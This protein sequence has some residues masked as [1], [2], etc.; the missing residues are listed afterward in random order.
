MRPSSSVLCLVAA[1]G[2]ASG[3]AHAASPLLPG[4][5]AECRDGTCEPSCP[6]R[7]G[8][9]GYYAT[10]WRR[11]PGAE[12]RPA[13]PGDAATPAPP[14]KS[15][16]PRADEESPR[17]PEEPEAQPEPMAAPRREADRGLGRLVAEADTA[18]LAD[19]F[20]QREFTARLV[21]A[22]LSEP[23]PQVRCAILGLAAGF[24]TAAAESI[25]AGAL[26]DPDPLVRGAACRICAERHGPDAVA[27][28][29]RRA[30]HDADLGVRLR[31]VRAL[32]ELRAPAAVPDLVALLDDPDPAI[33][34]RAIAAL[35]RVSG[36][37][38]GADVGRWRAWAA[39]PQAL[40][41][42]SLGAVLRDLF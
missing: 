11:W 12:P 14:P 5:A 29:V 25:C 1:C 42:W 37:R 28:L 13:A 21:T 33:Q 24:E 16:V 30:R 17:R 23:D 31:A 2:I 9:H 32:G 27:R 36:K 7:P 4:H 39:D 35:E 19:D 40:P 10:H 41:Q 8:H 15:V 20:R 3:R 38:F 18:R 34:A 22:M 6:V 26:D